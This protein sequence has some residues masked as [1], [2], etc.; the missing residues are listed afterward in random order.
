MEHFE[1]VSKKV[2]KQEGENIIVTKCFTCHQT[3]SWNDIKG[4]G[5]YDHH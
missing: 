3:T 2:A 4:V 5:F 1:M